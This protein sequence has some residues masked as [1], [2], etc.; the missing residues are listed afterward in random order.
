MI[1][2]YSHSKEVRLKQA[3]HMMKSSVAIYYGV[4]KGEGMNDS[5]F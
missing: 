2:Q 4:Y 3:F 1:D 5:M